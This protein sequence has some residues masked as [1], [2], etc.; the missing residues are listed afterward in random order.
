MPRHD[1][2]F[3]AYGRPSSRPRA[4]IARFDRRRTSL[5]ETIRPRSFTGLTR[6]VS[7]P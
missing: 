1:L 4:H 6:R 2:A 5:V 7:N 3:D